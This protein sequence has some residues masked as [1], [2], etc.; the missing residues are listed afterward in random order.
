MIVEDVLYQ[1]RSVT[2]TR[3]KIVFGQKT[4]YLAAI[5]EVTLEQLRDMSRMYRVIL[6]AFVWGT[7]AM[8]VLSVVPIPTIFPFIAGVVGIWW[9]FGRIFPYVIL[10]ETRDG[11]EVV[12]SSHHREHAEKVA[13][14][15]SEALGLEFSQKSKRLF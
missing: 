6:H 13:R 11:K 2:I 8:L 4:V 5:R 12:F 7:L 15:L 14:V 10:A 1:D 9:L 3:R